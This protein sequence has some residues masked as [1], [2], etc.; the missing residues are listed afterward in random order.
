M[1][2]SEI[3]DGFGNQL[4]MYACGYALAKKKGTKLILDSTILDTSNLRDYE[5]GGLN[6]KYDL[7]LYIPRF[8]PHFLK[9]I[10]GKIFRLVLSLTCMKITEKT[11]T[12]VN[13]EIYKV[14][15]SCRLIGY[16]QSEKYFIDYK[17]EIVSM[18]TPNYKTSETFNKM[19]KNIEESESVSL[20]IRRGDFV[21]LGWCLDKNYYKKAIEYIIS[22]T[23]NPTFYIFS[24]DIKYA[25]NFLEEFNINKIYVNYDCIKPTIED[26]LLMSNC[27]HNIIANS[28]YSWWGGYANLNPKKI[29]CCPPREA[30][31]FFYPQDWVVI[32]F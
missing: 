17:D 15:K 16:W 32:S 22:K 7:H 4:F 6:I 3:K 24:D 23:H 31:D 18:L 14:N 21:A 27:K 2:I 1:I 5:L 12:K 30:R 9:R 13:K 29:V 28:T 26:F 10:T 25:Q 19:K 8:L 20:H 11:T